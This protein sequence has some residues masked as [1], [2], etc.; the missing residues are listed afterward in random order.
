MRINTYL[1]YGGKCAEAFRFYEQHL[2]GKILMMGT[3]GSMPDAHQVPP[4]QENFVM[5]ARLQ[6]G[7][8]V[9]MGS[10]VPPER[11]EPMRSVYISISVDDSPEAERIF[12]LLAEG[13]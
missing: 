9:L 1:N 3:Y 6:L 2:G 5:H 8:T 13:G 12:G 7:D 10:D 11:F 4:G